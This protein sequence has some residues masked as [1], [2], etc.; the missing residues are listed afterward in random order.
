MN[1]VGIVVGCNQS[2]Y[3]FGSKVEEEIDLSKFKGEPGEQQKKV[4]S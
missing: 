3:Y 4:E 1:P 2:F